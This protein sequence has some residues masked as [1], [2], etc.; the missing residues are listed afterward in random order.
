MAVPFSQLPQP[1]LDIMAPAVKSVFSESTKEL[2]FEMLKGGYS[3]EYLY[4][5]VSGS[6][7]YV[8]KVATSPHSKTIKKEIL[9]TRLTSKYQLSPNLI[10]PDKGDFGSGVMVIDY[11]D[12]EA[13][14]ANRDE[15]YYHQIIDN[16]KTL[17]EISAPSIPKARSLFDRSRSSLK[18]LKSPCGLNSSL[19]QLKKIEKAILLQQYSPSLIH[20]DLN[21]NNIL[22][23]QGQVYFIDWVD[24]G[25][26]DPIVDLAYFTVLAG[27]DDKQSMMA[28]HKYFSPA[29]PT[30]KEIARTLLMRRVTY[31]I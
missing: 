10:Y 8:F 12:S 6:R 30:Q 27:M 5:V 25:K 1:I 13:V 17:H 31:F 2:D 9:F 22:F 29:K 20:G 16:L 3:R 19:E 28:L 11:I 4:K 23:S 24:A 26:G 7:A 18:K 21:L 14:T 15:K